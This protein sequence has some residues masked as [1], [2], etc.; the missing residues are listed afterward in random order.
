[1]SLHSLKSIFLKNIRAA[2][3]DEEIITFDLS[4]VKTKWA[5]SKE[6]NPNY[7]DHNLLYETMFLNS[8]VTS[9]STRIFF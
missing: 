4:I 6:L 3:A 7:H 9:S 5:L 1:M 8:S 2:L